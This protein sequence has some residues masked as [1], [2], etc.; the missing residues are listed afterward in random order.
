MDTYALD[1]LDTL[2]KPLRVQYCKSSSMRD[3][4]KAN[5]AVPA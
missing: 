5:T 1:K 4:V 2:L 3:R